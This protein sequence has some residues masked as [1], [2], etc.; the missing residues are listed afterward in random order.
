MII[1]MMDGVRLGF[2][3]APSPETWIVNR[4]L[5]CEVWG[6]GVVFSQGL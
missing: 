1:V 4:Q 2:A 5:Y 3:S 6:S